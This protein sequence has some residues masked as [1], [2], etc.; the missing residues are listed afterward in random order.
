MPLHLQ[1][2]L[3]LAPDVL[4]TQMGE[5]AVLLNQQTGLYLQLNE[6]GGRIF[7]LLGEGKALPAI[8]EIL[9]AEYDAPPAQINADL[10]AFA[11]QL[12]SHQLAIISSE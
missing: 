2:R 4:F 10:L 1:S 8:A 9:Q 5:E 7:A 11:E 3:T 6:V 12:V